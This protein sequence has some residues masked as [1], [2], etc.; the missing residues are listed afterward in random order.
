MKKNAAN[1]YKNYDRILGQESA[2]IKQNSTV[3]HSWSKD[4]TGPASNMFCK[5]YEKKIVHIMR[6]EKY[7]L[8]EDDSY[9]KQ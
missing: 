4:C 6:V 7:P 9:T 8:F 3:N 5:N 1:L 2:R